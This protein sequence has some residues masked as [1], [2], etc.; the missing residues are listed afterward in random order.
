MTGCLVNHYE[1]FPTTPCT[2]LQRPQRSML[3]GA[4]IHVKRMPKPEGSMVVG[5]A[6]K[7]K[8]NVDEANSTRSPFITLLSQHSQS[9]RLSSYREMGVVHRITFSFSDFLFTYVL[10]IHFILDIK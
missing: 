4:N 1:N 6:S 7:L 10:F 5:K 9:G 3:E 2:P 8:R